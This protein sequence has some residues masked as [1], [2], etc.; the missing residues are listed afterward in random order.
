MSS[1]ITT[2]AAQAFLQDNF[3]PWVMALVPTVI[4][5]G[6]AGA[7]LSIPITDQITRV[8][9]IVSGQTLAALAD[10][11]MV[12]GAGCAL[13]RLEA[14]ATTTL[15]TQFLRPAVGDTVEAEVEVIRAGK[16]MMFARCTLTAQP[17]GKAVAHATATMMRPPPAP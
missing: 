4:A 13:G 10:T 7:T 2:D 15:D 5:T 8:G 1:P 14:L 12:I 9:G 3:A 16:A 11:A 6:A 17:S